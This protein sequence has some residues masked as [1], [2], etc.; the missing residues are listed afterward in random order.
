MGVT[1]FQ[2]AISGFDAA[3]SPYLD[4]AT[5]TKSINATL[6]EGNGAGQ[7]QTVNV[8]DTTLAASGTAAIDLRLNSDVYGNALL[9]DELIL[10]YV[11]NAADGNGGTFEV[12]PNAVNGLN[13]V[14]GAA[15]AVKLPRGCAFA[16]FLADFSLLDK[17]PISGTNKAFDVVETSTTQS[18]HLIVHAWGR[19]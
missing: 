4:G 12:R 3:A 18:G 14:L 10:L 16:V 2:L 15:S 6:T 5:T 1:S 11:E 9:M 17:W 13:N 7:V 19:R 8:V